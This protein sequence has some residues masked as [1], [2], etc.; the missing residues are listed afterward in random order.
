MLSSYS[1]VEKFLQEDKPHM[2]YECAK[3][4]IL[5]IHILNFLRV[6]QKFH[7]DLRTGCYGL[8]HWLS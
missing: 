2:F 3:L 8:F 6:L 1:V 5:A 4:L 7:H